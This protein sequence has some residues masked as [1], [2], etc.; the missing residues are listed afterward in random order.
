MAGPLTIRWLRYEP[1]LRPVTRVAF[2]LL[3]SG[4]DRNGLRQAET[5]DHVGPAY[6]CAFFFA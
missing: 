6:D 3:G 2:V 5:G 1:L 4:R